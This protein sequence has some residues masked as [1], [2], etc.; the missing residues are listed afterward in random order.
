MYVVNDAGPSP[1]TSIQAIDYFS[2][3]Q[4]FFFFSLLSP[5]PSPCVSDDELLCD[6]E[7][8]KRALAD[9]EE[10]QGSSDR[11][12][13]A[14]PG[15]EE[16]DDDEDHV[17]ELLVVVLC[18]ARVPSALYLSTV[19]LVSVRPLA[20]SSRRRTVLMIFPPV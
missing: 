8:S 9:Q 5:S 3:N 15:E 20:L 19:V 11:P 14:G 10:P 7:L 1:G 13:A 16:D 12:L 2:Q 17:R 4:P 6:D 18:E